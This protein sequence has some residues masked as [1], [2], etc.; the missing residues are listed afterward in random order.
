MRGRRRFEGGRWC[1]G[2]LG[3]WRRERRGLGKRVGLR[4]RGP[5]HRDRGV[6]MIVGRHRVQLVLH[7]L[8]VDPVGTVRR[9]RYNVK[10]PWG[11]FPTPAR[12]DGWGEQFGELGPLHELVGHVLEQGGVVHLV[13]SHDGGTSDGGFGLLAAASRCYVVVLVQRVL[14][15]SK[16]ETKLVN[17]T[18]QYAL[19]SRYWTLESMYD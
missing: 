11:P 6:E 4:V 9:V 18:T 13:H 14:K 17:F 7:P 16:R 12:G 1:K 15:L 3:A 5:G 2:R 8:H 10:G 19:Q